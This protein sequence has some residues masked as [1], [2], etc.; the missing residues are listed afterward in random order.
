[1][2]ISLLCGD[3]SWP[4]AAFCSNKMCK[5]VLSDKVHSKTI[6]L[7]KI[8]HRALDLFRAETNHSRLLYTTYPRS[9]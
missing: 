7:Y 4:M 6:V 9:S 2:T 5:H 3:F 8:Q 1:M